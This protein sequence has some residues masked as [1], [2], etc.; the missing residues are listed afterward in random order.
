MIL[1]LI[2]PKEGTLSYVSA[3]HNPALLVRD[4]LVEQMKASGPALAIFPDPKFPVQT[5]ELKPEDRL[6]LY[7]DGVT[8]AMNFDQQP[9]GLDRLI[10]ST[11]RYSGLDPQKTADNILWD[12]RR[13]IGLATQSDDMTL[14]VVKYNP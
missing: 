14:M 11:N 8:D 4:H 13:F 9:F 10:A 7:T 5:I 3:G 12:V 6:I 1:G 2:D